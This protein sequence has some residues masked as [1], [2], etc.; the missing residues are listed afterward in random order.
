MTTEDQV[1]TAVDGLSI[2]TILMTLLDKMPAI[3]A[4]AAF[5][6][7]LIRIWETKTVQSAWKRL[8]GFL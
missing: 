6:W 5:V 4:A 8:R 3:A 7:T 1:K 2:G